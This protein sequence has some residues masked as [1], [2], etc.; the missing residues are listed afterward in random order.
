MNV[1]FYRRSSQRKW[2]ISIM[3]QFVVLFIEST[4]N[5]LEV[6]NRVMG[7][8]IN[9]VILWEIVNSIEEQLICQ[10]CKK[11]EIKKIIIFWN[12]FFTL[13]FWWSNSLIVLVL[14]IFKF[15]QTLSNSSKTK[16][17]VTWFLPLLNKLVKKTDWLNLQNPFLLMI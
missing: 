3:W 5:N 1:T 13:P 15:F 12:L 4:S 9:L 16:Q 10:K 8:G 7:G 14:F 17:H 11:S 6:A 2:W